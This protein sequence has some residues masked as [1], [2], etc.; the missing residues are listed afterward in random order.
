MRT[1]YTVVVIVVIALLCQGLASAATVDYAI[2]VVPASTVAG[3]QTNFMHESIQVFA[4][5]KWIYL[6][7]FLSE[8]V[9]TA[10]NN[11]ALPVP[12]G[13]T[14]MR[15]FSVDSGKCYVPWGPK[16]VWLRVD[17]MNAAGITYRESRGEKG[18][19]TMAR[20]W[21]WSSHFVTTFQ[22]W[23]PVDKMVHRTYVKIPVCEPRYVS[24]KNY[25]FVDP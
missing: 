15:N 21:K 24:R 17:A 10:L 8:T 12:G 16:P 14:I 13:T 3:M 23:A 6:T 18:H 9:P 20:C 1:V 25:Y 22:A 11:G 19:G 2:Q 4:D 7:D 5:G